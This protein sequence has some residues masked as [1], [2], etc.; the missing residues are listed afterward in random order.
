M[1]Y[2]SRWLK[3]FQ[4]HPGPVPV[5][6]GF[7]LYE[8]FTGQFGEEQA[9]AAQAAALPATHDKALPVVILNGINGS[10]SPPNPPSPP[11]PPRPP[12]PF[13][14][15]PHHPMVLIHKSHEVWETFMINNVTVVMP[16]KV[17]LAMSKGARAS[18]AATGNNAGRLRRACP[19][20]TQGKSVERR[21]PCALQMYPAMYIVPQNILKQAIARPSWRLDVLAPW[22]EYNVH[23][24]HHWLM[25]HVRMAIPLVAFKQSLIHHGSDKYHHG[26]IWASG[27][28]GDG[29]SHANAMEVSELQSFLHRCTGAPAAATRHARLAQQHA[30][31]AVINYKVH[32][33]RLA[34]DSQEPCAAC[35]QQG[36]GAR[37]LVRMWGPSPVYNMTGPDPKPPL[38]MTADIACVDGM[39]QQQVEGC[40]TPGRCGPGEHGGRRMLQ[41]R[42]PR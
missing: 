23:F 7:T 38:H 34:A 21:P 22:R 29:D 8:V 41:L 13:A 3:H 24:Q 39:A 42:G 14:G 18:A 15:P 25:R 20:A 37:F 33:N 6:P 35:L 9:P 36:L 11:P 26:H 28:F 16:H 4:A 5:I 30:Q 17:T 31:N 40:D 10:P 27:R 12:S 32:D 19:R 2:F 1:S